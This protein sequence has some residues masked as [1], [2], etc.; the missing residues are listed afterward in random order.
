MFEYVK[1]YY[2][3]DAKLNQIVMYKGEKGII[4]ADKGHY[5]GVNFDKDKAG[6]ISN[7][8]PTDENLVYTSDIGKVRKMTRSQKRY[9]D[10]LHSECS[11]TFAE[12]IGIYK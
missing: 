4:A 8:H 11:E 9:Q 6:D 2:G 1:E 3:V 5:I 7:V 12:Y 10:Y